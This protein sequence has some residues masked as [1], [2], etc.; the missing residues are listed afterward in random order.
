M[1]PTP[2]AP[3]AL[4]LA[5]CLAA[6]AAGGEAHR[7]HAHAQ[8]GRAAPG[9]ELSRTGDEIVVAGRL[10]HT[11]TPVKLWFDDGGY[12]GYDVNLRFQGPENARWTPESG[13]PAARYNQRVDRF[14][15]RDDL[16]EEEREAIR[17][18]WTLEQL[19]T[20][21]DQFVM[22]YDVCGTSA[23]CF[24]VLHDHRGL[25]VQFMLDADGMIYQ[26]LDVAERAWHAAQANSRSI[27]IEIA[28]IGAYPPD[29]TSVLEKWYAR[30]GRGWRIVLPD[31]RPLGHLDPEGVYRP[32]GDGPVT[33]II[34]DR[35]LVQFD[36]TDDQ[37]TALIHLTATL[38]ELFPK[39]PND[40]PRGADGKADRQELS[41]QDWKDFSGLVA[42]WHLDPDKVDPGPA[43]DWERVRLGV[44]KLLGE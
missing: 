34:H 20:V 25:S 21:V 42:H 28:N 14:G 37:Y 9:T 26:T 32:S 40:Y 23:Y 12:N 2:H 35:D 3:A 10:F 8:P 27:G 4:L 5:A 39:L 16:S 6:P 36:L 43:F 24:E 31:D 17:D 15:F 30:D 19:G 41:E 18:G 13:V 38:T 33:G 29:D 1:H 11:G 44:E 7:D 22:H